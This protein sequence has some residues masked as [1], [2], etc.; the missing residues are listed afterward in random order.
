MGPS[1]SAAL[2]AA[3]PA[4]TGAL[5]LRVHPSHRFLCF[6]PLWLMFVS[7]PGDSSEHCPLSWTKADTLEAHPAGLWHLC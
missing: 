7:R 1:P 4:P 5:T 3:N 2:E 6:A